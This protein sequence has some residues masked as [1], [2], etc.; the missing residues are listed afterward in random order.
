[1]SIELSHTDGPDLNVR[2]R[3]NDATLLTIPSHQR[4][5]GVTPTALSD[6]A[7][8]RFPDHDDQEKV[9]DGLL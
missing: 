6:E 2:S 1:M 4:Q 3:M 9:K 7:Q 8:S 5:Y